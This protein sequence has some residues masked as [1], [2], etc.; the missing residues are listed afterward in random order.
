MNVLCSQDKSNL[1]NEALMK[2]INED[3]RIHLTPAKVKDIYMLRLVIGSPLTESAD[4]RFAWK[5][6]TE[7]AT[8][9]LS[10]TEAKV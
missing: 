5:T 6:I 3:G 1:V 2:R 9:V 4:I 10:E 8:E 7:L